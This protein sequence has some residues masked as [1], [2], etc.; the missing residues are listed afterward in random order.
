MSYWHDKLLRAFCTC[1]DCLR[2]SPTSPPALRVAP[3]LVPEYAVPLVEDG[4][5]DAADEGPRDA[6]VII[7]LRARKEVSL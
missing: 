7:T 5:G 3:L 4:E 6:V 1:A 2:T